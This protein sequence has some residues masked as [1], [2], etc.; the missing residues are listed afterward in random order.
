MSLILMAPHEKPE[1]TS[2]LPSPNFGDSNDIE[3]EI[4]IKRSMNG[5]TRTYIKTSADDK[6][7]YDFIMSRLKM[8]EVMNFISLY[9]T[10]NVRLINHKGEIYV[11]KILNDP[12]EYA[13]VRRGEEGSFRLE[14]RGVKIA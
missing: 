14:F 1:V 8:V 13:T 6:L 3:A 4:A 12:F 9:Y 5:T 10:A 2:L 11:G 7:V